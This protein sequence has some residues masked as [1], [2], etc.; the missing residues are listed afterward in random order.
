MDCRRSDLDEAIP[1]FGH[2]FF[3]I[4]AGG[5]EI[6]EAAN[7]DKS[8]DSNEFVDLWRQSGAKLIY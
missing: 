7:R 3:G 4:I 1:R 8:R 2:D 5:D 6:F